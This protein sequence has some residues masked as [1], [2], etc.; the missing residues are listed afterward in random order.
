MG[1][2][3]ENYGSLSYRERPEAHNHFDLLAF[4]K[5][6]KFQKFYDHETD[7]YLFKVENLP[8]AFQKLNEVEIENK[9]KE[10]IQEVMEKSK[11][12]TTL[13][14]EKFVSPCLLN[15]EV[16][17]GY[18]SELNSSFKS[19]GDDIKKNYVKKMQDLLNGKE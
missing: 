2:L 11:S 6:D 16:E 9:E 17:T 4:Q 10:Q 13:L 19:S 12:Q 3:D 1:P 14:M 7:D 8:E 15:P 18:F 5:K